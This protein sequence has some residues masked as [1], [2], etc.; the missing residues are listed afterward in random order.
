MSAQSGA[1]VDH[2]NA[3]L[4]WV[5]WLL[6][7]LAIVQ[8]GRSLVDSSQVQLALEEPARQ[9]PWSAVLPSVEGPV[10]GSDLSDQS[11]VFYPAYRQVA[12]RWARGELTLWNPNLYAGVPAL[13]NPQWGVL[14]PQVMVLGLLERWGGRE[15]FDL[16]LAWLAFARL[17]AAGLGTWILARTLGLSLPGAFLAAVTYQTSGFLVGWLGHSLG[18]VAPVL[19]WLLLGIERHAYSLALGPRLTVAVCALLAW[20]GGHPETAFFC[21]LAA[22]AWAARLY[23]QDHR[24]GRAAALSLGWGILMSAPSALPFMEYLAHSGALRAREAA[25]VVAG[26]QPWAL[27]LCLVAVAGVQLVRRGGPH[28]VLGAL[29]FGGASSLLLLDSGI[30]IRTLCLLPGFHG[31]PG[32]GGYQGGGDFVEH[33]SSWVNAAAL[34]L[35]LVALFSNA[36]KLG[37]RLSGRGWIAWGTVGALALSLDVDGIAP[38]WR[39]LPLVGHGAGSRAAVVSALGLGLLA[40]EGLGQRVA[41]PRHASVSLIV[42]AL[43]GAHWQPGQVAQLPRADAPD[44]LH[45]LLTPLPPVS[46]GRDLHVRGW[47]HRGLPFERLTLRLERLGPDG[48]VEPATV[49][50]LPLEVED[51]GVAA[52]GPAPPDGVVFHCPQLEV[53]ALPTGVWTFTLEIMAATVGGPVVE[54]GTR[55][56]GASHVRAPRGG[57]PDWVVWGFVLLMLAWGP[58]SLGQGRW[59]WILVGLA[60]AQGMYVG[61]GRNP[62]SPRGR[63]FPE[64]RTVAV[65]AEEQGQ[66]VLPARL[67]GGPGVLVNNTPL[68]HGLYT[69]AGYDAMDVDT[70]D[71]MRAFAQH[72]GRAP[73]LDWNARGV[74]LTSPAWRMLGVGYLVCASALGAPPGAEE[75]ELIAAPDSAPLVAETYVYRARSPLARAFCVSEIVSAEQALADPS[76]FDPATQAFVAR[77]RGLDL[78]RPFAQS[79]VRPISYAPERVELQVS[80]D[81]DG[82]LVLCEQNYPGWTVTVDGALRDVWTVNSLL[83]GVPLDSGDHRVVFEFSPTSWP[84]AWVMVLLAL[85][86]LLVPSLVTSARSLRDGQAA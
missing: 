49:Q 59:T 50:R 3:W 55:R 22:A 56:L 57:W 68:V 83:R 85:L 40:G 10:P 8:V 76:A 2:S 71:G 6:G 69:L 38:L 60:V 27:G 28:R 18:H 65:L 48:E 67:L 42:L 51:V 19:P 30:H 52:P 86:G 43:I 84:L 7:L 31:L 35:A 23:L 33:A 64:T 45:G 5:P 34:A 78:A 11:M 39:S 66:A 17:L 21:W 15:A 37:H 1:G 73:L 72:P 14:D 29:L 75:W 63:V 62:A 61:H 80:L 74:D 44:S 53:A 13:A 58:A 70:F 77:D 4:R 82:L 79:H 20:L 9:L 26:V 12:Q 81:G 25:L 46:T 36:D 54:V 16:G 47:I 32:W 24:A 41:W